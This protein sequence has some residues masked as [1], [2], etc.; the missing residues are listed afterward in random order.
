MFMASASRC[1]RGAASSFSEISKIQFFDLVG[2]SEGPG[3]GQCKRRRALPAPY[4][5]AHYLQWSLLIVFIS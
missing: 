5:I 2:A 1:L 3:G 4:P